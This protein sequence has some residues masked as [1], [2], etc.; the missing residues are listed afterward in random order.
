MV[1][2]I[3]EAFNEDLMTFCGLV[4]PESL[5]VK[6][7]GFPYWLDCCRQLFYTGK[8]L[9]HRGECF[10]SRAVDAGEAVLHPLVGPT[11]Q[12]RG[13]VLPVPQQPAHSLP[14]SV[15]HIPHPP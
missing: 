13:A 8:S 9:L 12:Q 14:R 2:L 10:E 15:V 4:G 3:R 5:K 6:I 11:H 1:V 7:E